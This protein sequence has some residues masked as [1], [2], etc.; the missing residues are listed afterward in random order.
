[1]TGVQIPVGALRSCFL[2]VVSVCE[3][4]GHFA[5]CP[6]RHDSK[7]SHT[8][9]QY[10]GFPIFPTDWTRRT[11]L[12]TYCRKAIP[13]LAY[14]SR[15]SQDRQGTAVR[16][17]DDDRPRRLSSRQRDLGVAPE[18]STGIGFSLRARRLPP[19]AGD[20]REGAGQN[21]GICQGDGQPPFLSNGS[22]LPVRVGVGKRIYGGSPPT[23]PTSRSIILP[24]GT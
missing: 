24:I 22:V 19:V 12:P 20:R 23:I 9:A 7:D 5:R 2:L 16:R 4:P 15:E 6:D 21:G 3:R 18:S 14:R 1:M 8:T 10:R 11:H 17:P 13:K